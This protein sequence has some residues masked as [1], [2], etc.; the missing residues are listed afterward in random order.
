MGV[1]PTRRH[2]PQPV[3]HNPLHS[4]EHNSGLHFR[5]LFKFVH[6]PSTSPSCFGIPIL[7][8]AMV[9]TMLLQVFIGSRIIS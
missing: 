7:K 4:A 9:F 8:R 5:R 3:S 1:H 2:E 6:F